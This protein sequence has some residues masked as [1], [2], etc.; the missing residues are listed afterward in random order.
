VDPV[1]QE[2]KDVEALSDQELVAEITDTLLRVLNRAQRDRPRRFVA[3]A[4][5]TLVESEV[6][7]RIHSKP[8]ITATE[9]SN[10][11]AVT[12]SAM[13]QTLAR[14]RERGF[15]AQR[16]HPENRRRN[17]LTLTDAGA[18]AV[19][20]SMRHYEVLAQDVYGEPRAELESYYRFMQKL[21]RSQVMAAESLLLPDETP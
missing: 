12:R 14:L 11:L 4:S 20:A 7:R 9:L 15:V 8:G 19:R 2:P 17:E 21:E 6:C 3:G 5:M 10:T 16:P 13:S 1:P 18:D